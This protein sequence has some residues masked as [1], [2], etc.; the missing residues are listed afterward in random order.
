MY[1]IMNFMSTLE[2]RGARLY[3]TRK[4]QPVARPRLVGSAAPHTCRPGLFEP[5]GISEFKAELAAHYVSQV[6]GRPGALGGLYGLSIDFL[7]S[8]SLQHFLNLIVDGIAYDL[9]KSGSDALILRP[10][11]AAY[12]ALKQRNS[13][14]FT[15]LRIERLRLSFEDSTVLIHELREVELVSNL[16]RILNTLASHY[17][18]LT[19]RSGEEPS[20]I[21]IPVVE[22]PAGDD[23]LS[24]FREFLDVDETVQDITAQRYLGFW[25]LQYDFANTSRVYDVEKEVLLDIHF[26]T[27]SE[28]WKAW[29]ERWKKQNP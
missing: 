17:K 5:E 25:G 4:S 9:V 13:E 18:N 22:D 11:V 7:T 2:I 14:R 28:Y 6:R 24:R 16:D 8:F 15:G 26:L 20:F 19:L 29:E 23:R 21:S 27:Q 10:F 3:F 1:I 12:K